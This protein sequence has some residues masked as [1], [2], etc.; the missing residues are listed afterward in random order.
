MWMGGGLKG[1]KTGGSHLGEGAVS[2]EL[3]VLLEVLDLGDH[4]LT[5]IVVG[6]GDGHVLHHHQ[7]SR[8]H[9]TL[10]DPLKLTPRKFR[11]IVSF[12]Q[13][14]HARRPC[15][16]EGLQTCGGLFSAR[17]H[18]Q[19]AQ[20]AS[21]EMQ[22]PWLHLQKS[23]HHLPGPVPGLLIIFPSLGLTAPP[24]PKCCCIPTAQM[25][26]QSPGRVKHAAPGHP[27]KTEAGRW[28]PGARPD[29][30]PPVEP[31]PHTV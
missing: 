31:G 4:S 21:R 14:P 28:G 26:K 16:G 9:L 8:F 25:W 3:L 23:P 1:T 7:S 19:N 24:G 27:A 12:P 17:T 11:P 15:S 6:L 29:P 22:G 30:L 20:L 2:E 13:A 5:G 18:D 10:V